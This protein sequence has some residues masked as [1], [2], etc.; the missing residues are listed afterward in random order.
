LTRVGGRH[1]V[2]V[3]GT[4]D[5]IALA[6]R[7][8]LKPIGRI[9]APL[10]RPILACSALRRVL[11]HRETHGGRYDLIHAWTTSAAASAIRVTPRRPILATAAAGSRTIGRDLRA[12]ARRGVPILAATTATRDRLVRAAYPDDHVTVMPSAVDPASIAFQQRQL[13][14]DSWGVDETAFVVGHLG[15]PSPT[16]DG[17]HALLAVARAALTG[18]DFRIVIQHRAVAP[19]K[20]VML[21]RAGLS[22]QF[23]VDDRVSEPWRVVAGLDAAFTLHRAPRRDDSLSPELPGPLLWAMA[24]G[25]PVIAEQQYADDWL[26]EGSTGLVTDT[27]DSN[28]TATR[29]LDLFDDAD[30]ARRVGAAG[31]VLVTQRFGPDAFAGRIAAAWKAVAGKKEIRQEQHVPDVVTVARQTADAAEHPTNLL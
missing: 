27:G 29:L 22:D 9:R 31:K 4:T 16:T 23:V 13:L 24:A 10:N 17:E 28:R 8:G 20:H 3:V 25:V 6:R 2:L 7:C 1:D 19:S 11:R 14:R 26:V 5:H 21:L 12:I 18:K 30:R 15:E